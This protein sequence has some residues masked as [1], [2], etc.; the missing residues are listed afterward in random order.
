VWQAIHEELNDPDFVI[1]SAAQDTG[2][3]AVA[4]HLFDAAEV[5]YVQIVDTNHAISRAFNFVNV[6]SAAWI[7]ET[8]QIVRLDEGTYA[9]THA[10]GGT[11]QYAPAVKDWVRNGADSRYV[12]DAATVAENI[13]KQTP[14]EQQAEAAFRLGN[15]FREKGHAEK[16]EH[17]WAQA[18]S[19]NPTNVNF[20]RQNLTLSEE[21]SARQAY[22]EFRE[23]L[24]ESGTPYYRP[25]DPD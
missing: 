9:T 12:L 21:G 24:D 7:D 10:F 16:A 3:E 5:D 23:Q 1:L 6:P 8:G 20:F 19:L 4:G 17:Y 18:R 13:R 22:R 25:L 2:G 14:E 15:H 11:D